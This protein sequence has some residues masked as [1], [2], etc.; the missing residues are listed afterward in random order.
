[1]INMVGR[2]PISGIAPRRHAPTERVT[3]YSSGEVMSHA[4]VRRVSTPHTD[5]ICSSN[6]TLR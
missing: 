5:N 4:T 2:L 1:M 6:F 3:I